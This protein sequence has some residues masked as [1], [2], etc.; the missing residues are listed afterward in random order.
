MKKI[1]VITLLWTVAG[2]NME[3]IQRENDLEGY[4]WLGVAVNEEIRNDTIY[5]YGN[6]IGSDDFTYRLIKKVTDSTITYQYHDK[7][8]NGLTDYTATYI[9]KLLDDNPYLIIY[10]EASVSMYT[11]K[12][13]CPINFNEIL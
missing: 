13:V 1:L 11:R 4:H 3:Y 10:H 5:T 8:T 9:Q 12:R 2:C 6:K 7:K